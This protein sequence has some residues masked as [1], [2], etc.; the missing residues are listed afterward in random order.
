MVETDLVEGAEGSIQ[1]LKNWA[2]HFLQATAD[3]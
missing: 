1:A 2:G 3:K